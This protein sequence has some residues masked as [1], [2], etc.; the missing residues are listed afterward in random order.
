MNNR[1]QPG[2]AKRIISACL[3][4]TVTACTS[5]QRVRT[6]PAPFIV[7]KHPNLVYVI[8]THGRPYTVEHPRVEGDSLLGITPKMNKMVGLP[9]SAVSSIAAAQADHT[10]TA[11]LI[12]ALGAG[13]G[14][15]GYALAHAGGGDACVSYTLDPKLNSVSC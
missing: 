6:E 13:A 11:L 14:G 15:L 9:L 1:H 10:R 4:V 8:D 5:M 3:L 12:I 7:A 2:G